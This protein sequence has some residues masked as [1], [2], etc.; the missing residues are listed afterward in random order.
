MTVW[1]GDAGARLK[2]AVRALNIPFTDLAEKIR[3]DPATL[4]RWFSG[5]TNPLSPHSSNREAFESLA[6]ELHFA[7][8]RDLV[9]F[10]VNDERQRGS[11]PVS[12]APETRKLVA[13][14]SVHGA[15]LVERIPPGMAAALREAAGAGLVFAREPVGVGHVLYEARLG[16]LAE[17]TAAPGHRVQIAA[18]AAALDT[19]W[20]VI[21]RIAR[22]AP[23]LRVTGSAIELVPPVFQ[24]VIFDWSNTLADEIALDEAVCEEFGLRVGEKEF[25]SLLDELQA[26]RDYRW[27]DY[28]YLAEQC[29][30]GSSDVIAFH[31][32]HRSKMHWTA[33]AQ[34]LLKRLRRRKLA[35][36]TNCAR[37]VLGLRFDLLG[38][39]AKL[40]SVVIT[41]TDTH[42]VISKEASYRRILERMDIAPSDA[43][44]VSDDYYRD[45]AAALHLGCAAIWFLRES[46]P[47]FY[48][49]PSPPVSAAD[50]LRHR[51]LAERTLPTAIVVDHAETAA[52]LG[53]S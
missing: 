34:D 29:G 35:L 26:D 8:G 10:L 14:V 53:L 6:R 2:D 23:L 44:V 9:A 25:R 27:F 51:L 32:K 49:S 33:G 15:E 11:A 50:A 18:A 7:S 16:L 39:H 19:S 28:F 52:L 12:L 40:F 41:S 36:A 20:S 21:E 24:L 45:V 13:S 43:I 38:V 46:S 42:D 31:E 22:E 48:G 1:S 30:L 5:K 37:D 47:Q 17:A 3:T 4:H